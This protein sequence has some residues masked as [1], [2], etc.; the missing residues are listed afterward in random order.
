VSCPGCWQIKAALDKG[1][2]KHAS[3]FRDMKEAREE[4]NH[5]KS[6]AKGV[7]KVCCSGAV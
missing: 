2:T 5:A 7:R 4:L 1:R 3:F 6:H